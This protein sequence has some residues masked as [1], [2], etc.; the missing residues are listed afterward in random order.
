MNKDTKGEKSNVK[1]KGRSKPT[2]YSFPS[3]MDE[4]T[5]ARAAFIQEQLGDPTISKSLKKTLSREMNQ[6]CHGKGK[7]SKEFNQRKGKSMMTYFE[8]RE[9]LSTA[10]VLDGPLVNYLGYEMAIEALKAD[11]TCIRRGPTL[12]SMPKERYQ[13]IS[14]DFDTFGIDRTIAQYVADLFCA[15]KTLFNRPKGTKAPKQKGKNA[16]QNTSGRTHFKLN[17]VDTL[18]DEGID[19]REEEAIEFDDSGAPVTAPQKINFVSG[20]ILIPDPLTPQ[21]MLPGEKGQ[22]EAS[23][24]T[25]LPSQESDIPEIEEPDDERVEVTNLQLLSP[26]AVARLMQGPKRIDVYEVRQELE[27]QRSLFMEQ[28]TL[29]RSLHM[30]AQRLTGNNFNLNIELVLSQHRS[31]QM[32]RPDFLLTVEQM[33]FVRKTIWTRMAGVYS[34]YAKALE[35]SSNHQFAL[36]SSLGEQFD[37]HGN[38]KITIQEA[39][40]IAQDI[41]EGQEIACNIQRVIGVPQQLIK[42]DAGWVMNANYQVAPTIQVGSLHIWVQWDD[43]FNPACGGK[44]FK[45]GNPCLYPQCV[46][47]IQSRMKAHPSYK[48]ALKYKDVAFAP[49]NCY[50]SDYIGLDAMKAIENREEQRTIRAKRQFLVREARPDPMTCGHTFAPSNDPDYRECIHC[51]AR[52]DESANVSFFK[53][54]K[55]IRIKEDGTRQVKTDSGWS[56]Y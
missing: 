43:R 8:R 39:I 40:E 17:P 12:C 3:N 45:Y 31:L 22:G 26:Q 38:I 32:D 47:S 11:F 19:D 9:G 10:F 54:D 20:G 1:G 37:R 13:R 5:T 4:K 49:S 2:V 36:E 44:C 51:G 35:L 50:A 7:K 24:P 53:D 29:I 30:M 16:K 55:L 28:E 6:I 25:P 23:D 46:I 34:S 14:E 27:E 18:A 52:L 48:K 33:S 41:A 21:N 15:V 56:E 42:R